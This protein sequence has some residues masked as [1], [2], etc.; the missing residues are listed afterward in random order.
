MQPTRVEPEPEQESVWD[1]PHPPQLE[2]CSKHIQVVFNGV[3]I[4]DSRRAIR[5]LERG[6]PPSYYIPPEDVKTEYLVPRYSTS[7]SE[8][9]GVAHYY[10]LMVGDKQVPIAAWYYI[11]PKRPYEA[12]KMHLAFYAEPM[13][14][15]TVDGELVR[16][17]LGSFYGGWITNDVVGPFKGEPGE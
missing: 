2:K 12:L 10:G 11:D 16:P 8:W 15:C 1:Y 6:H 17:Q 5:V 13:D 14:A 7:L 4:A 3:T 9:K